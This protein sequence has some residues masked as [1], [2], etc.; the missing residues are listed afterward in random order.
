M[1]VERA[2]NDVVNEERGLVIAAAKAAP[3]AWGALAARGV[4]RFRELSGR[5]PSD[6]E[7]RAIWK[8]LW[9]AVERVAR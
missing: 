3:K 9:R 1:T 2:V 6:E 8:E 7:R 5:A 4:V